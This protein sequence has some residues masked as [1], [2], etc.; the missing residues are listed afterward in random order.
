MTSKCLVPGCTRLP[1][2]GYAQC[3][4]HTEAALRDAFGGPVL[5][6]RASV[7]RLSER[8]AAVASGRT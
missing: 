3:D 1:R 4:T 2:P 6:R 8:V 5:R 7:E